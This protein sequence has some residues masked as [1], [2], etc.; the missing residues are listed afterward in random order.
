MDNILT[1]KLRLSLLFLAALK[2]FTDEIPKK[3]KYTFLRGEWFVI[4]L[5]FDEFQVAWTAM[6]DRK[7]RVG[8]CRSE[9]NGI[10][11]NQI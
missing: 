7:R 10:V 4:L 5:K 6:G 1:S 3:T 8:R 2:Q 11:P 9:P